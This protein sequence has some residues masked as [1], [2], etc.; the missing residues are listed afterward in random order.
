[1]FMIE[2]D[3]NLGW[4]APRHGPNPS[5]HP[6]RQESQPALTREK[7]TMAMITLARHSHHAI[8]SCGMRS[9]WIAFATGHRIIARIALPC[10]RLL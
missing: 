10:V 7:T 2:N 8:E 9:A 3:S 4:R 5:H 6:E 1:M